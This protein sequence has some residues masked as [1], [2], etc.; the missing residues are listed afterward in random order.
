VPG[1]DLDIH[2]VF[3]DDTRQSS[4][5]LVCAELSSAEEPATKRRGE[6]A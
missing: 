1:K 2:E 4:E 3:A 5:E 6:A